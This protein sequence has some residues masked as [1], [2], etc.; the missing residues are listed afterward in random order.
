MCSSTP[1]SP[2][3]G[4]LQ[5]PTTKMPHFEHARKRRRH[6]EDDD[7]LFH[8]YYNPKQPQDDTLMTQH[9]D[10]WPRKILP[11]PAKRTKLSTPRLLEEDAYKWRLPTQQEEQQR[12]ETTRPCNRKELLL[13]PCHVCGD[14]P[15]RASQ[16]DAFA[17]CQGCGEWTCYICIRQCQGWTGEEGSVLSEQEA[18]SRSFQMNDFNDDGDVS[19]K[20]QPK[21]RGGSWR[22]LG[23]QSIICRRCC[24]EP[25]ETDG[26]VAC[27]GCYQRFPAH[28]A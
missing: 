24:V 4:T 3:L 14:H 5:T 2:Y 9:R 26:E 7:Q 1:I 27:F 22:A 23:H 17:H 25:Q 20:S 11:V 16:L 21:Q 12:A 13:T 19:P 10:A 6:D 28:A 8:S 18:L 15:T